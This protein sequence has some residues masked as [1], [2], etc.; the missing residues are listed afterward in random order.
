[1]AE[2]LTAR[3]PTAYRPPPGCY[4]EV[5]DPGGAPREHAEALV[6]ELS[7]L[8]PEQLAAAGRR[9]DAI[10]MQQGITFD[11]TGEEGTVKDRP[12]PL[13]LVPR[14]LPGHEWTQI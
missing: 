12:F 4:D 10:F 5:F 6:A 1:M 8:G 11:A 13:D 2:P 3:E 9:R 7:R 14:I